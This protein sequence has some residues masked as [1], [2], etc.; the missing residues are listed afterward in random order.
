MKLLESDGYICTIT[1]TK[2]VS[3]KR[4]EDKK[5]SLQV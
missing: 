3:D 5:T 1:K 4:I 2:S